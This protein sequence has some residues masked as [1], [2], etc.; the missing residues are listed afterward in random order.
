MVSEKIEHYIYLVATAQQEL[1]NFFWFGYIASN[2]KNLEKEIKLQRNYGKNTRVLFLQK[3]FNGPLIIEYLRQNLEDLRFRN[4]NT[5]PNPEE[6]PRDLAALKR[7]SEPH[8]EEYIKNLDSFLLLTDNSIH[9]LEYEHLK[10]IMKLIIVEFGELRSPIQPARIDNSVA[11]VTRDKV[12]NP[13]YSL[14][15]IR[16]KPKEKRTHVEDVYFPHPQD[17]LIEQLFKRFERLKNRSFI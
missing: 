16:S 7:G 2:G 13:S 15:C 10:K 1:N 11:V 14:D 17:E 6:S 5:F 4:V 8:G 12:E 9:G 3:V